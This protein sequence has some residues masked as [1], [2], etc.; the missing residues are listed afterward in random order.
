[1]A[2]YFGALAKD[3]AAEAES[4]AFQSWFTHT[5]VLWL[6]IGCSNTAAFQIHATIFHFWYEPRFFL[7]QGWILKRELG[8]RYS[9]LLLLEMQINIPFEESNLAMA[10]S[11]PQDTLPL[12]QYSNWRTLA[13]ENSQRWAE[14]WKDKYVHG[15]VIYN[16]ERKINNWM[17]EIWWS[18]TGRY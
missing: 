8:G 16:S 2:R 7:R 4:L 3:P 12:V 9:P 6:E 17:R 18:P 1:M 15:S 10:A 13:K 11:S 14:S 5:L